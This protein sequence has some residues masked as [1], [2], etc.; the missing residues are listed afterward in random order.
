MGKSLSGK[1]LG[2][3][4]SQRKEDKKYMARFVD[5]FGKRRVMYAD[6]LTEIRKKY[7]NATYENEMCIGA[8]PCT[9]TLNEW[10]D[11][12]LKT[13]KLHCRDSTIRT[14]KVQYEPFR[15]SIG[16]MRIKDLN[17]I[18]IQQT[19]N[20]MKSDSMR[21]HA[22]DLLAD[23]LNCAVRDEFLAKNVAL[24]VRTNLDNGDRKERRVLEKHEI[25]LLLER[26]KSDG[27]TYAIFVLGIDTGM[28]I[29]EMLGLCWDCVDFDAK[30]IHV[31]RSLT[32]LSSKGEGN[33]EFHKP[34]TANSI[35]DIPMTKRVLDTLKEIKSRQ[36]GSKTKKG[37]EDLVFR[38]R[39]GKP[40]NAANVRVTFRFYVDRINAEQP[41]ANLLY[42]T[43]HCLRHTFATM[44][45]DKGMKPKV[46]QRILGHSTIQMTMD[47][48]CH[49]YESSIR[50]EM[51]LLAEMA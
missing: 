17:L 16:L 10:F 8:V 9:Y 48:Y 35:R 41:E 38:S 42:F 19:F 27:N 46:L 40:I 49:V 22:K 45:I 39:T 50:D 1:E 11:I 15:N 34:K 28:R 33:Y 2:K 14:Y 47:L 31:R 6:T 18:A 44:C 5:R 36:E 26:M 43:P 20:Q 51:S 29:G 23:I 21:R 7:R 30:T 37:F 32:Y 13:H 24:N 4:I 25:D 12:C 3:G